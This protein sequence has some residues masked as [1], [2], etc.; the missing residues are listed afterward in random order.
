MYVL[1]TMWK[2]ETRTKTGYESLIGQ[3]EHQAQMIGLSLALT[4]LK[5][6]CKLEIYTDCDYLVV[7]LTNWVEQWKANNWITAKGADVANKDM[8]V[9]MLKLLNGHEYTLHYKK[10]H[11]YRDW[12]ENELKNYSGR[13]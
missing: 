5:Q 13:K 9:L 12:M 8:W 7:G 2:Q 6:K 3:T 1:E 11:A 4:Q 10:P